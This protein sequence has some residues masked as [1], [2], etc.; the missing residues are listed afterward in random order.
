MAWHTIKKT[1]QSTNHTR[2]RQVGRVK[3]N[4]W[5]SPSST[6]KTLKAMD[7]K[8]ER[9]RDNLSSQ[10]RFKIKRAN[11]Y[12]RKA[13]QAETTWL[14][15]S[16]CIYKTWKNKNIT[17]RR[18]TMT[19]I[20][21]NFRIWM[22]KSR[23]RKQAPAYL[24]QWREIPRPNRSILLILRTQIRTRT[25]KRWVILASGQ[26]RWSPT[27]LARCSTDHKKAQTQSR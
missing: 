25:S 20:K 26:C 17:T 22:I 15:I 4:K 2:R 24:L 16:T 12:R 27:F 21:V 19:N 11:S 23:I 3:T 10:Y 5:W 1:T 18:K 7:Q 8:Q 6:Q 9:E 13:W 14:S